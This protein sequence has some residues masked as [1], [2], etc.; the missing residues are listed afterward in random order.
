[1]LPNI[2]KTDFPDDWETEISEHIETYRTDQLAFVKSGNNEYTISGT[3]TRALTNL[4][5]GHVTTRWDHDAKCWRHLDSEL[6]GLLE[7][8]CGFTFFLTTEEAAT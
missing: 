2:D 8:V 1:M 4:L 6:L 7:Q 5:R 3:G